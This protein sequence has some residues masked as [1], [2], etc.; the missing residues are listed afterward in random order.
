MAVLVLTKPDDNDVDFVIDWLHFYE[1]KFYRC[2][3]KQ[4]IDS[5]QLANI[6][7]NSK[8][9]FIINSKKHNEKIDSIWFRRDEEENLNPEFKYERAYFSQILKMEGNA[10]RNVFWNSNKYN[11]I[12]WLS[13]YSTVH[14]DKI[15]IIEM[16]SDCGLDIPN[17]LI[18][19]EKNH[20][21]QFIDS[22]DNI[23]CKALNENLSFLF[24]KSL[25]CMQYANHISKDD[26]KSFPD[27]FYPSL[28][29]QKIEKEFD[30]RTFYLKGNCYSMAIFN[31]NTDF[32]ENYGGNR[33]VPIKLP[34]DI[35][36]KIKKLM[37]S[38][39]LNTGSLD[40]VKSKLNQKY[41][42]LEVNP[43]GQFSMVSSPCNYF[44]EKKIAKF[45]C[46]E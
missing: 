43:N 16:A 26:L 33:N 2:T 18:T 8:R 7:S 41:Y 14:K 22:N 36:V 20:L 3:F 5:F 28:F 25:P 34:K 15:K 21:L 40:F 9:Q 12:N 38:L 13:S 27:F 29:Q 44:I 10:V 19:T 37:D 42:F 31:N 32:R 6:I 4:F 30:I 24:D 45:L 23:I 35:E 39:G 17:T 1:K 46:D 11:N